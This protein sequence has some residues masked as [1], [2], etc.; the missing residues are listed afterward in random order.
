MEPQSI[1]LGPFV[2]HPHYSFESGSALKRSFNVWICW[3]SKMHNH[4]VNWFAFKDCLRI[5]PI[6]LCAHTRSPTMTLLASFRSPTRTVRASRVPS[7]LGS[8]YGELEFVSWFGHSQ[9][10]FSLLKY[11]YNVPMK[12]SSK[13]G[14]CHKFE[15]IQTRKQITWWPMLNCIM[16]Y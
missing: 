7:V 6:S 14:R 12:V 1:A 10:W 4:K 5:W 3:I 8:L 15:Y 16:A 2:Q 11:G 9:E 13:L